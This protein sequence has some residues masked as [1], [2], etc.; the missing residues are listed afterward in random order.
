M[1]NENK[2]E[3][4]SGNKSDSGEGSNLTLYVIV[5]G[6]LALMVGIIVQAYMQN[7]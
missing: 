3:N 7:H 6:S 2:N 4:I 5:F 1:K